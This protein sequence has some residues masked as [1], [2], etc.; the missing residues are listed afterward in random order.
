[1]SA[2]RLM[3]QLRLF[4]LCV[5]ALLTLGQGVRAETPAAPLQP[6]PL[7]AWTVVDAAAKAN[8]GL[9]MYF[10]PDGVFL[11]VDPHSGLGVAGSYTVGRTGL[12]VYVFNYGRSALFINGDYTLQG[13]TLRINVRSSGFMEPQQ[14]VL[15]RMRLQ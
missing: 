9:R 4:T 6:P 2:T 10:S 1:M 7:G 3:H 14:V 13:D 11:M 12:L 15:Q 8:V 5:L